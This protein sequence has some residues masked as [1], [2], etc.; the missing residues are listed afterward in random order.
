[1]M[2]AA[3][4]Q[5]KID[6]ENN[7]DIDSDGSMDDDDD[8]E[9]YDLNNI[10]SGMATLAGPCGTY[11]VRESGTLVVVPTHPNKRTEQTDSVVRHD[12][13]ETLQQVEPFPL[14]KGQTL[15]VVD[16]EDGVAKLARR[17]GYV[18]ASSNQLVKGMC[19]VSY[20]F[21]SPRSK[22]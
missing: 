2:E 3:A 17:S 21:A 5:L 8:D 19:F 16:F 7:K 15:Q 1:M 13:N 14:M 22:M 4:R 9:A 12:E 10:I 11:A 6:E 20:K 18:V